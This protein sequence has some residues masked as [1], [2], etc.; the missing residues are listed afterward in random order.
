MQY[1]AYKA[2]ATALSWDPTFGD[3]DD[4]KRRELYTEIS[5]KTGLSL[6]AL[7]YTGAAAAEKK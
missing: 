4:A 2:R 6:E 5:S 1:I 7:G 3:I